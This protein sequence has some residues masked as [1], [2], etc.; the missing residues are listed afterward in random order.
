MKKTLKVLGVIALLLLLIAAACFKPLDTTPYKETK[1]YKSELDEL[2]YGD[3][4][5]SGAHRIT[6]IAL[7]HL[8]ANDSAFAKQI[9]A[10]A[11]SDTLQVGWSRVNLLPPFTTPIAID[12][13]RGGKHFEGVHDSIYVRAFVFKQGDTKVAYVSADLLIIPPS[14]SKLFDNIL[15]K[16]GFDQR[17][18][19]FTATHTHTSIGAW[20][21]SYVGEKFAGKYDKRVPEF[22]AQTIATAILAAEQNCSPASIGYGSF[23]TQKLVFNRLITQMAHLPDSLG[24]VDSILRVVKIEKQ[25]GE[26]AAIITFAAHN[27][28]YHENLMRLSADWCGRLMSDLNKSREINFASFSAGAVGSHGPVEPFKD[29]TERTRWMGEV[30]E[31]Q[32]NNVAY[33]ADGIKKIVL[34][35]FDLIQTYDQSPLV[36]RHLP[37]FLREP[38]LRVSERFVVRPWLFKKLF[39]DEKTYINTLQIGNIFFAGTPCDFSGELVNELDS[40]AKVQGLSLLVTSFNGGYIGYVTD[41]RRY[42]LNTYET[43]VMG[44]FGPG[45]GDYLSEVISRIMLKTKPAQIR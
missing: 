20:Y 15:A 7:A 32:D 8:A 26:K 24:E 19:F 2:D 21:D 6:S 18:I 12:A 16:Q 45:N 30:F 33:V 13:H 38:N 1:F 5:D 34:E 9:A 40:T 10:Q 3:A 14:V 4:A 22:I 36:M 27:T 37:L 25:T 23:P 41:S 35:N 43:R 28:I 44:W 39:G 29:T 42:E 11:Q 17:N 31:E